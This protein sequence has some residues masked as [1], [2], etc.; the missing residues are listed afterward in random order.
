[1]TAAEQQSITLLFG[2]T[3]GDHGHGGGHD[4]SGGEG[5]GGRGGG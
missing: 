4:E 5:G 1:M 2:F 3:S